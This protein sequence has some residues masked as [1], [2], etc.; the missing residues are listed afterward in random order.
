ML[1]EMVERKKMYFDLLLWF[2][3]QA[4]QLGFAVYMAM[5]VSNLKTDTKVTLDSPNTRS[6]NY[7]RSK[8]V[9]KFLKCQVLG[10]KT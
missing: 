5:T 4:K 6:L 1:Q 8:L 2:L 7:F 3:G 10:Y 9:R